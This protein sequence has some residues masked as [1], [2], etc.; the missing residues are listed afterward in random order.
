[1]RVHSRAVVRHLLEQAAHRLEFPIAQ[2]L[3]V[4]QTVAGSVVAAI[5]AVQLDLQRAS[6]HVLCVLQEEDHQKPFSL[7]GAQVASRDPLGRNH[8]LV[9]H[10]RS[11]DGQEAQANRHRATRKRWVGERKGKKRVY[12]QGSTKDVA[13]RRAAQ[14]AKRDPRNVSLRIHGRDGRIQEER[15]YPLCGRLGVEQGLIAFR[16]SSV[17]LPAAVCGSTRLGSTCAAV[18]RVRGPTGSQ[19]QGAGWTECGGPCARR[20]ARMPRDD[21]CLHRDLSRAHPVAQS[22]GLTIENGTDL[23]VLGLP[24][25]WCQ[26]MTCGAAVVVRAVLRTLAPPI[27]GVESCRS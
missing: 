4:D 18:P 21:R 14:K 24:R 17:V 27:E 12:A 7:S 8:L 1:M 16:L 19:V 9:A 6:V 23:Q 5:S 11:L 26:P 22:R 15:T 10:Q 13:V 25:S 2:A 20:A 3:D